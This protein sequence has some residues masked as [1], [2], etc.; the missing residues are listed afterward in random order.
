[1]CSV[2]IPEITGCRKHRIPHVK[3]NKLL[4]WKKRSVTITEYDPA[5]KVVYLGN[6]ITGWAKGDG[7]TDK[8]LAT[9]WRNYCQS[10]KSDIMM[11]V[12]VTGSGLKAITK[13][14]GLTEYWSH[15]ITHCSAPQQYARVFCWIYRHEGRKLKQELRCHAVL[16][17]KETSSKQMDKHLTERLKQALHE[18]R[19]EKICRQNA[20]LCLANSVYA[21]PSLPQR[22]IML[23]IGSQNYKPPIERSKSAPKLMSIDEC[24]EEYELSKEAI[25]EIIEE[26]E[27]D[28]CSSALSESTSDVVPDFDSDSGSLDDCCSPMCEVCSVSV[29]TCD[30]SVTSAQVQLDFTPN[31]TPTLMRGGGGKSFAMELLESLESVHLVDSSPLADSDILSCRGTRCTDTDSLSDHCVEELANGELDPL[32]SLEEPDNISD[33]SGYSEE[34]EFSIRI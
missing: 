29:C 22:K 21:N 10:S 5:F 4:N 16:C 25:P 17:P 13:E 12:T 2:D 30:K 18:F 32:T 6:V 31:L 33:E 9:L 1:M 24:L 19:R 11:K 20:R 8:P 7:C 34:K 28:T 15:R 26:E 3:L 27:E 23:S 14:H